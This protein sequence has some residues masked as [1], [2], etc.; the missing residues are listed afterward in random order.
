MN[1]YTSLRSFSKI[2]E[3]AAHRQIFTIG[4]AEKRLEIAGEQISSGMV[5]PS[6]LWLQKQ[7]E[8]PGAFLLPSEKPKLQREACA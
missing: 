8:R 3:W 6:I 7:L 2:S 5:L 4:L 1:Q